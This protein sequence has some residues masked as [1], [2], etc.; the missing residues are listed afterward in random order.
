MRNKKPIYLQNLTLHS[1]AEFENQFESFLREVVHIENG[2]N[3]EGSMVSNVMI[4]RRS[5]HVAVHNTWHNLNKIERS[6]NLEEPDRQGVCRGT[7]QVDLIDYIEDPL[8]ALTFRIEFTA[9]LPVKP[10]PRQIFHTVAWQFF[11]PSLN[12][13]GEI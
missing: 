7:G 8:V 2:G 12:T 9:T 10:V 3:K 13:Q 1:S 11:M 4:S 5:I 6:I